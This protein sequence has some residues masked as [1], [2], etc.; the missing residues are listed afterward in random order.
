MGGSRGCVHAASAWGACV[1]TARGG[2][3]QAVHFVGVMH[4]VVLLQC[5]CGCQCSTALLGASGAFGRHCSV[6]GDGEGKG[7]EGGGEGGMVRIT[8]IATSQVGRK[9]AQSMRRIMCVTASSTGA[10]Q[11][12][13]VCMPTDLSS[14]FGNERAVCSWDFSRAGL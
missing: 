14:F 5:S 3:V 6:K 12:Q 9:S 8:E 13:K 7:G 2:F 4:C 11:N 10:H 1:V